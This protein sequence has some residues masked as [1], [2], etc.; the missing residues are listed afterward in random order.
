MEKIFFELKRSSDVL[1]PTEEAS[2]DQ[3]KQQSF[4]WLPLWISAL[5]HMNEQP[6]PGVICYIHTHSQQPWSV[7][8]K[9]QSKMPTTYGAK[10]YGIT[11]LTRRLSVD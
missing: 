5:T 3:L 10:D 9:L 6:H 11:Q 2:A 8:G 7:G 4:T 1:K